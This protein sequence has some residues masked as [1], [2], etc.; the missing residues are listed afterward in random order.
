[1][2]L[3]HFGPLRSLMRHARI[4]SRD[5][6]SAPHARGIIGHRACK[7]P[8]DP[9]S[10]GVGIPTS[11]YD[12][13]FS[14]PFSSFHLNNNDD[15]ARTDGGHFH[16]GKMM[17]SATRSMKFLYF[18]LSL[19]LSLSLSEHS[20]SQSVRFT[21]RFRHHRRVVTAYMHAVPVIRDN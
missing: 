8:L 17:I 2:I 16:G 21:P 19:S 12:V 1:M 15:D 11:R 3:I 6:A 14:S 9:P 18:N 7:H 13:R 10:S 4:E 20:V 5:V